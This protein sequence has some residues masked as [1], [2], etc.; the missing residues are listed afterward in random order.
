MFSPGNRRKGVTGWSIDSSDGGD[1]RSA[2]SRYTKLE[3]VVLP[4]Y[5]D[6]LERWCLMMKQTISNIACYFNSQRMMRR[7][8]ARP[9][10][11]DT[12]GKGARRA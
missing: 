1:S 10:C 9:I 8:G 2:E 12:Q 3:R 4:L 7:Y 11:A 5:Y 6:E